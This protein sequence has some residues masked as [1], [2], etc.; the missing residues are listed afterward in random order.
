MEIRGLLVENEAA[1]FAGDLFECYQNMQML[2]VG[3]RSNGCNIT[4]IGGYK[5]V[6]YD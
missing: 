6:P 3:N 1:L 5:T 2:K 4:G